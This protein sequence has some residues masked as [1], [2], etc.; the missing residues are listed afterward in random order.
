MSRWLT[1]IALF[2]SLCFLISFAY[3][4]IQFKRFI[5]EPM[6]PQSQPPV[7]IEVTPGAPIIAVA[8]QLK[9]Q[10]LL[11]NPKYFLWYAKLKH[12]TGRIKAG[13]YL[14][15]PG[16]TTPAKLLKNMV[17][18]K[19]YLRQFTIV[20]GWNFQQLLDA[21]KNNLYLSQTFANLTNE[22]IMA[23]LGFPNT[24]PE[25][26]FFPDTYLF[27]KG[28]ADNKIFKIA[29]LKMQKVKQNLWAAR[30]Q[31]LP[32]R[33]VDEALTAASL[34]EKE[35]A[36]QDEKPKIAGVIIQRLAKNMRLQI[37]FTVI[38]AM[39]KSFDGKL[40]SSDLTF[41][42]P[43]NTYL[44]KGLP[45]S[46]IAIPSPQSIYAALHPEY[47]DA[48]YYVAKGGGRHEFSSTLKGQDAAIK[49]YLLA[50]KN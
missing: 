33:N 13:E 49:K 1:K 47:S 12:A 9:R 26:Q 22:Q 30:A 48:L 28:T 27:A 43:Y 29:Y 4:S 36:I 37:D 46:P 40:K 20:E 39:G 31:G 3:I 25:G 38:Y 14:I 8:W 41:P 18:G 34:I 10:G 35:T 17:A 11:K 45:P 32:Y 21:A 19:I 6:V 44:N 7:V 23:K 24:N 42:S 16:K 2:I 5:Y 50:P 15:K